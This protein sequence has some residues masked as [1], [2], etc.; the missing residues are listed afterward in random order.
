MRAAF[1]ERLG[2]PD[3]I[4]Y[5]EVPTPRIGPG[6][7]LVDV[8]A[9]TV[10]PVDTFVR[11]GRFPTPMTFPFV[12]SRDL[13]GR[14]A[15]VGPA[16][17]GFAVGDR[18]WAN[19]RGHGGR[20]GSAAEQAAGAADR[21]YHLPAGADPLAAV[22]V[23]HP[24]ATAHLALFRHGRLQ[25]GE[26]V[27]VGG[28]A[29]NVGGALV[30]L[31]AAAGARVV[32]TAH[33]RDA[34]HCRSLGASEVADYRDPRSLRALCPD[35]VDV[36]LDT[37]GTNDLETTVGLLAHRGRIVLLAGALSRPVLP[38]GPLYMNDCSVV[39]FA[40]SHATVAEL[41]GAAADIN[42]AL[43]TLRPRALERLPLAAAA[44]AHQRLEAGELH[45]RR[46]VLDPGL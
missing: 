31:A 36:H 21:L 46:V 28:A 8:L 30:A 35:G 5:G 18:V 16:V 40:I 10:N 17:A 19:R 13:V 44:A 15:A 33:P 32:A 39:G 24:A 27:G 26:T 3:V 7:V 11:S 25:A 37:S 12:V 29:G 9:A 45:G 41:A 4:G 34:D 14:V 6:E 20:Q 23:V 42:D 38:V 1:I 22:A 43:P 2:P